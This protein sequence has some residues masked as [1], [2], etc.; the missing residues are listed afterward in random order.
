MKNRLEVCLSF[1]SP[2]PQDELVSLASSPSFVLITKNGIRNDQ[3]AGPNNCASATCPRETRHVTLVARLLLH[4][5][6]HLL[7]HWGRSHGR[8]GCQLRRLR[9]L[10]R[11]QLVWRHRLLRHCQSSQVDRLDSSHRLVCKGEEPGPAID[12]RHLRQPAA[13]ERRLCRA[14]AELLPA[15]LRCGSDKVAGSCSGLSECRACP[16]AIRGD[17]ALLRQLRQCCYNT[18]LCSVRGKGFLSRCATSARSNC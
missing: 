15:A 5:C 8:M 10:H 14:A 7:H 4:R 6:H 2:R 13:R 17:G 11:R 18:I 12:D 9:L 1:Y 16:D 3:P